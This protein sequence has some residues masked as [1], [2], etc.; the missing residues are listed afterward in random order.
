MYIARCN[1]NSL[2]TGSR[3]NIQ[4]REKRH[5]EGKGAKYTKYRR[6]VKI[7]YFEEYN[8]LREAMQRENQIKRWSKIKKENLIKYGHPTKF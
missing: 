5:N 6:P 4:A 7:I 8:T 3:L 1:D 2:Y